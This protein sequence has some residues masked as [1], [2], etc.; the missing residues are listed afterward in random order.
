VLL[1]TITAIS[2]TRHFLFSP[3]FPLF[4]SCLCTGCTR[5]SR[6]NHLRPVRTT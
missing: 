4:V 1:P 2:P 3:P 5:S 6:K